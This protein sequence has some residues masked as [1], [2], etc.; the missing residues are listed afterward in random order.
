VFE[1]ADNPPAWVDDE[2]AWER[3]KAAVEPSWDSYDEPWAVV[4]FVYSNMKGG[5]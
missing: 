3:A 5:A 1:R 4:A 2:G